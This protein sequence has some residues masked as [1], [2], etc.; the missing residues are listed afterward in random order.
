[1]FK[2]LLF[3]LLA[4]LSFALSTVFAKIVTTTSP[5]PAIELTFFR[6]LLGFVGIGIYTAATGKSLSPKNFTF[7]SLRAVFN[8]AAVMCFF[9]GIE[10]T[11]VS[12]ANMLNMTYP[13]FV[14]IMAPLVTGERISTRSI[15][16]LLF[17]VAG[18]Y[19]VIIPSFGGLSP[20]DINRGD[21]FSLLSGAFAAVAITSLRQARKSDETHVILFYLMFFGTVINAIPLL[22]MFEIPRGPVV[23]HV[24]A[25][26]TASVAGQVL[27]T[28]GYRYIEAAPGSLVSSSRILF[29]LLLGVS[30]FSDPL[31]SRIAAGAGLILLSLIGLSGI[32][33]RGEDMAQ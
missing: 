22:A 16:L 31:T 20:G 8:T 30:V 32:G 29:G 3:L 4:E 28:V 18:M 24:V 19:L 33:K 6:F 10:Q 27:I 9:L 7:I 15:L 12:K 23:I 21:L 26:T 5:V 17:A 11:T 14:F 1:M 13:V 2:G 25:A